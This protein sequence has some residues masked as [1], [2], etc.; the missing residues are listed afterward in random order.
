MTA[1]SSRRQ[2]KWVPI[3]LALLTAGAWI[4]IWAA[5][6][7]PLQD[8]PNHLLKIDIFQRWMRGEPGVRQVYALNLKLLANYTCYLILFPLAPIFGLV[9]SARILL[10]LIVA[11]LPWSAYGFLRRVNPENTLFALA[12]PAL[13]FSLF[14][15]MGNLNFC[16]G[17]AVYLA[18]L[19]VFVSE[20]LP[21]RKA[22]LGFCFLAT[23]LYFTHGFIFLIL[24]GAVI[25]LVC[26]DPR[27]VRLRR[28]AGLIPGIL[29]LAINVVG[30]FAAGKQAAGAF[31][32]GMGAPGLNSVRVALVWLLNPHGWGYDTTIAFGWIAVIALCG[33]GTLAAVLLRVRAEGGFMARIRENAW[34]VFALVLIAGFFLA[35]GQLRDWYHL[36]PRFSPLTVLTLLGALRLPKGRTIR[37]LVAAVLV[38]AAVAI[39]ARNTQEFRR[40]GEQVSEYVRGMDSVA[41]G[42]SIL[43][44]ENVEFGPKYRVNLHSWAY[45]TIARGGWSPYLH[46]QPSY[47]PVIYKMTPWAPEEGLPLQSEDV[48]RRMAACYDYILLWNPKPGDAAALRGYFSL[49][50]ATGHLRIWQNLAGLRRSTPASNPACRQEASTGAAR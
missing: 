29:C 11:A 8:L 43:P 41:E 16:L 7:P 50:Q 25:F 15:V 12:V 36:R 10:S 39:E 14:F 32:P 3:L 28:A 2:E 22:S 49:V 20:A 24:V 13:N 33:A 40:R 26:L 1:P 9:G 35:P 34:L 23:G 19:T 21:A 38:I 37:A 48:I 6:I 47:N 5:S 45:Y 31:T 18:A 17:L 30:I 42:S 46:S 4:P 44:V 27:P